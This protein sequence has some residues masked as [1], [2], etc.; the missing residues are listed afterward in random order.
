MTRIAIRPF[1]EDGSTGIREYATLAEYNAMLG[2]IAY[3][4]PTSIHL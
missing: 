4:V 1:I 2:R 3:L